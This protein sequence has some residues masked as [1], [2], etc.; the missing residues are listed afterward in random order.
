[1]ATLPNY[2]GPKYILIKG[3]KIE[4]PTNPSRDGYNF[5]YWYSDDENV[6]FDFDERILTDTILTAKWVVANT[7]YT[8]TKNWHSEGM[9]FDKTDITRIIFQ[10]GMDRGN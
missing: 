8:F 5:L 4:K 6:E 3:M 10:K 2:Q 1:M 7:I 9:Y